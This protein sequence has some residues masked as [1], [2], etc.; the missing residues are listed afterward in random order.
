MSMIYCL[1]NFKMEA[2]LV[3]EHLE[4][5]KTDHKDRNT[6]VGV[7]VNLSRVFWREYFF[8]E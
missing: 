8:L 5:N 3:A 1:V 6:F 2:N 4:I 7:F